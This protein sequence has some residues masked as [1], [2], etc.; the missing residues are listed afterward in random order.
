MFI[1]KYINICISSASMWRYCSP[2]AKLQQKREKGRYK[3]GE[4]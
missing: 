1:V 2:N 4:K 3:P